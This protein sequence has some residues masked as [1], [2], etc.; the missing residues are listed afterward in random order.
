[1]SRFAAVLVAAALPIATAQYLETGV[2][3]NITGYTLPAALKPYYGDHPWGVNV[4][5]RF[6]LK[7]PE[8]DK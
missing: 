6:R 4:Y 2:G 1:M 7:P 8:R 3:A 5:A